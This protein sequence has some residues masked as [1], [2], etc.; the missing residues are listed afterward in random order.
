[1][2][3]VFGKVILTSSLIAT[4]VAPYAVENAHAAAKPAANPA[5]H[6]VQPVKKGVTFNAYVINNQYQYVKN[7][8][9]KLVDIT[10]GTKVYAVKKTDKF[11]KVTFTQLPAE[12]NFAVYVNGVNQGYTIRGSEGTQFATTFYVNKKGAYQYNVPTQPATVNVV[13]EDGEA[14]KGQTVDIYRGKVKVQTVKTNEKGKAV[15]TKNIT[16]GTYYDVY[17]NGKKI[18]NNFVRSGESSYV[19]LKL[20]EIIK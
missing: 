11:G 2:K 15:F 6:K 7:Q 19:Y 12:R 4:T 5:H 16:V 3:N 10:K 18:N 8:V 13:N 17:V 9:V 1:M 20:S 14:V